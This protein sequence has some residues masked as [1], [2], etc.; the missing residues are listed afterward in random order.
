MRFS[1]TEDEQMIVDGVGELCERSIRAQAGAWDEAGALPE[2]VRGEL[3]ELGLFGLGSAEAYGGVAL[4]GVAATAV[5]ERLGQGD[6]AVALLVAVHDRL[7]AAHV[8][9][10]GTDAQRRAWLPKWASGEALATW[11]EPASSDV[12]ATDGTLRGSTGV[13]VGA[14][15]AQHVVVHARTDGGTDGGVVSHVVETSA[16]GVSV[17]P[18]ARLGTRA[19]GAA[20]V[21]LDGVS[22]DDD[23]R[24]GTPGDGV[25]EGL[26][27][28][29]H[30]AL[31]AIACG[32]GEAAL[33]AAT[34]YA[35]EREQFGRPI[36]RFQA[37]QWKLADAGT[38]L[39]AASLL[40]RRAAWALEHGADDGPGAA[41]RA[42]RAATAAAERACSDALQIHGGYGYTREFPVERHLRAAKTLSIAAGTSR[43]AR[44]VAAA[45]IL[46][47]F[48]R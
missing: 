12:V 13:V 16:P 17:E 35:N 38:E 46:R 32:V 4:S 21:R 15:L 48:D 30:L 47:R 29:Q 8:R 6:A 40:A 19:D 26:V 2:T 45:A 7:A 14:A 23:A 34:A 42:K 41:A 1:L 44:A 39:E 5:L 18:V 27:A 22:I 43:A 9:R 24:L 33:S 25:A 37:I 10:A 20:R 28:E 3:G 31:A 36:A 11:A